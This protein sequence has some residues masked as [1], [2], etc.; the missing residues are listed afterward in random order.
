MQNKTTRRSNQR[1]LEHIEN[2]D[3]LSTN[4]FV[5]GTT[6]EDLNHFQKQNFRKYYDERQEKPLR[7]NGSLVVNK[8]SDNIIKTER[9]TIISIDTKD[10]NHDAFPNPNSV[11]MPF[12]KSFYNVKKIELVSTE[13]PNTDQV[14]RDVPVEIRNNRI[15]WENLEDNDLG[16]YE[17]IPL[18]TTVPDTVDIVIEDYNFLSQLPKENYFITIYECS[19][20][21]LN[22]KRLATIVDNTTI[23]IPFKG[24]ILS[25]E[26]AKVDVGI[27]NYTVDLTPGNYSIK[28]LSEEFQRRMNLV[29]R[30]N[31]NSALFHFF[32]VDVDLS[33]DIMTFS[34]YITKQLPSDPIQTISASGDIQVSSLSHGY[35]VGDMVLITGAKSVG[36][37]DAVTLNGLFMVKEVLGLDIFVYE[38]N[39]R[40]NEARS[41]G[42]F[43]VKTGRPSDFRLLFLSGKSL[44][45]QNTGFPNEDSSVSIAEDNPIETNILQISNAVNI[46]DY[47]K[48][49]TTQPHSLK[50]CTVVEITSITADGEVTT[51]TPH[52]LFDTTTVELSDTDTTPK[53]KGLFSV[54]ATGN[55]TFKIKNVNISAPGTTGFVKHSGDRIN[56]YNFKTS[57]RLNLDGFSVENTTSNEFEIRANVSYIDENSIKNTTVGLGQLVI[58]HPNHGFN[59]IVSIQQGSAA[60]RVLV[61]TKTKHGLQG[62]KYLNRTIQSVSGSIVDIVI[63]GHSLITSDV[64]RVNSSTLSGE[65]FIERVDDDTIRIN[66][67]LGNI[68]ASTGDVHVGDLVT[69]NDTDSIP[70]MSLNGNRSPKFQV[71]SQGFPDNQFEVE[72]GFSITTQGTRGIVGRENKVCLNRVI[73][74]EPKSSVFAGIPLNLINGKYHRISELIDE[75]KYII[76]L[77]QNFS[78]QSVK[79]GGSS[80]VVSSKFHGEKVFQSNT[81][82]GSR[83]GVLFRSISLEGE[84]YVMLTSPNLNTVHSAGSEFQDDVFAKILLSEPPGVMMFN[85][86]ISAPKEF[87]P[88]LASINGLSFEIRRQDGY[89][90]NFN[91]TDFSMSLSIVESVDR[92]K[93][94]YVSSQTG[95]SELY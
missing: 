95:L 53:I 77:F 52:D 87:N 92:I 50:P 11:S 49:T 61:T 1:G 82:N 18:V 68:P 26:T 40:A 63:P 6:T 9:E 19:Y 78:N 34:S 86:F 41:G 33:T 69:F 32:T 55:F 70:S 30:R 62:I 35:K 45:V 31:G 58:T 38:V 56:L 59:E 57:P 2:D 71:I 42:G 5:P 79:S 8:N 76:R 15:S 13:F 91:N 28:T 84:N 80:V 4:V 72:A 54:I 74:P 47:I 48:F 60:G 64:I 39:D 93:N 65:Y 36:G 7:A 88:P 10:R 90:Y 25:P 43:T 44:V 16:I 89:L 22:G 29:K 67:R 83:T 23:R 37:I 66:P 17:E 27:P 14:I 12:G 81:S 46:G 75:N 21:E 24:G 85:S 3:L 73:S 51:S 20:P 94:S